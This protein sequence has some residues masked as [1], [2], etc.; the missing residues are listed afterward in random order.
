LTDESKRRAAGNIVKWFADT[1]TKSKH[2]D[3][4]TLRNLLALE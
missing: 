4:G 2:K 1:R 3:L